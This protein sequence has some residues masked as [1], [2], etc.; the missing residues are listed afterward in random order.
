M[1]DA[2]PIAS[3]ANPAASA[4]GRAGLLPSALR[5]PAA[6]GVIVFAVAVGTTQLALQ[7]TNREADRRLAQLGEVYL[8]GLAAS[9]SAGLEARDA[10]YVT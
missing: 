6:A 10:A 9:V 2:P 7:V 8:D 5:Q 1:D 3:T 4:Q